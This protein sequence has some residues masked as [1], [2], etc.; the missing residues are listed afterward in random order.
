MAA[1]TEA[2]NPRSSDRGENHWWGRA[3]DS[4]FRLLA[5]DGCSLLPTTFVTNNKFRSFWLN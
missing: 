4:A 1:I 5:T 3:V 2:V